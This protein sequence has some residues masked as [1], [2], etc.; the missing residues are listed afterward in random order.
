MSAARTPSSSS[1]VKRVRGLAPA[2]ATPSRRVILDTTL[3]NAKFVQDNTIK[4][5]RDK[6]RYQNQFKIPNINP[7]NGKN[8]FR[9]LTASGSVL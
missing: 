1:F 3:L 2:K 9:R 4:S 7:A 6:E 8:K 5:L